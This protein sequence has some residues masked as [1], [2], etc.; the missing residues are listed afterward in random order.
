GETFMTMLRLLLVAVLACL[1]IQSAAAQDDEPQEKGKSMPL[2]FARVQRNSQGVPVALET[3]IVRYVRSDDQGTV[4]VDLVGV[5]HVGDRAYYE[6]LNEELKQYDVV[7]YE[8]VA[9]Q[10]TRV[11]RGGARPFNNPITLLHFALKS[12]LKLDLQTERIDY[13]RDN[14]VHAD[15]SPQ[16]LLEAMRDRGHDPLSFFLSVLFDLFRRSQALKDKPQAGR[17]LDPM[18]ILNLLS[19]PEA[20]LKMK[21]FM[22]EQ[23]AQTGTDTL[24]PT[25]D[26]L[27]IEDRNAACLKV[28]KSELAKGRKRIA[29]FYGAAHMPDFDRRL[30]SAE[31]GMERKETRW[32]TAWDL[33][34]KK[35]SDK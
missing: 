13:T 18:E 25:L 29:I 16:Q 28:L 19:D 2:Q 34:D 31:F 4:E 3:A 24:G 21:R 33:S 14:F 10:G 7:L 9:P 5:I 35:N 17:D 26:A 27:L 22:A 23:M 8:L 1:L 32:L 20:P 12:A 30:T 6:K 11:P 15:L